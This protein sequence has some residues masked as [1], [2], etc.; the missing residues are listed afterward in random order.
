MISE[1]LISGLQYFV[2]DAQFPD[3]PNP[4][5]VQPVHLRRHARAVRGRKSANMASANMLSV[6]PSI[7]DDSDNYA[8]TMLTIPGSRFRTKKHLKVV[9]NTSRDRLLIC[10]Y[11]CIY[12]YIY[13]YIYT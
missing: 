10:M 5:L 3:H 8:M 1:V 13:I 4:N 11:V 12:V 2:P 9:V 6:L 7:A